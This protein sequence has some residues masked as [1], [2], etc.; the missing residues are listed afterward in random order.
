MAD[1]KTLTVGMIYAIY[2]DEYLFCDEI[3]MAYN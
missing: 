1:Y 2:C 3:F